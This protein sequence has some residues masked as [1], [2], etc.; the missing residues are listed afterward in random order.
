MAHIKSSLFLFGAGDA[1]PASSQPLLIFIRLSPVSFHSRR[2]SDSPRGRL[3]FPRHTHCTDHFRTQ[4][5]HTHPPGEHR[6]LRVLCIC[7]SHHS[8]QALQG[9]QC[10][11]SRTDDTH[12]RPKPTGAKRAT[13]KQASCGV[14]E[15]VASCLLA[16]CRWRCR[17]ARHAIANAGRAISLLQKPPQGCSRATVRSASR[18][19]LSRES[20]TLHSIPGIPRLHLVYYS[21]CTTPALM[22]IGS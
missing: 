19:T 17:R 1:L 21:S 20:S 14:A 2:L 8:G 3:R 13:N 5:A 12:A 6:Q 16:V 4:R 11:I 18:A 7:I 10:S 15:Q 9:V 22:I